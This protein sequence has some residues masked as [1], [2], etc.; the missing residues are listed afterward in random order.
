MMGK[1]EKYNGKI[2]ENVIKFTAICATQLAGGI[3][4]KIKKYFEMMLNFLKFPLDKKRSQVIY[5]NNLSLIFHS[6][7]LTETI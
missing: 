7:F 4:L 5:A 3:L 1:M 6:Y 2:Q